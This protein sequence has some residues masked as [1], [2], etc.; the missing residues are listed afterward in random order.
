MA[1]FDHVKQLRIESQKILTEAMNPAGL[2]AWESLAK[3]RGS[4][5]ADKDLRA[6][7]LIGQR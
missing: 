3:V 2:A 1:K 6:A 7:A 5:L 4:A